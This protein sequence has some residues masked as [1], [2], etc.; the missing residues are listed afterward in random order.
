MNEE[1]SCK[2]CKHKNEDS[3]ACGMCC[4]YQGGYPNMW[5]PKDVTEEQIEKRI[6]GECPIR[7]DSWNCLPI[8]KLCTSV[9]E[10]LC[11]AVHN[12]YNRGFADAATFR[13][14]KERMDKT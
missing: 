14:I 7:T 11:K 1:Y 13:R 12:A 9:P 8:G 3:N 5:E 2:T 6:N 4:S 10:E